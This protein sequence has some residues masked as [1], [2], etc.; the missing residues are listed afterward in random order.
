MTSLGDLE[1]AVMDVLWVAEGPLSA[2][3]VSA[4]LPGR[5]PAITTVLTVLTRLTRKKMVLRST[6][7]R[8]HLY[9]SSLSREEHTA[10]LMREALADSPD[11]VA[12]LSRFVGGASAQQVAA[13]RRVL[14]DLPGPDGRAG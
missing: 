3:D 9:R 2:K 14:D 7:E 4:G 8:P 5:E 13:L 12:V 10:R 6:G 11:T 1:R